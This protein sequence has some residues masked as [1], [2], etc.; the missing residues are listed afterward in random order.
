[1]VWVVA[2]LTVAVSVLTLL[3]L[4]L[5]RSH[6]EL[7]RRAAESEHDPLRD[8]PSELAPA[9]R[10]MPEGVVPMPESTERSTIRA[11]NG[12]DCDLRPYEF[13]VARAPEPYLLLAFLST[14]CLS[15]LDIWRDIIDAGSG[16]IRIDAGG[17]RALVLIV[18]KGREEENLGKARALAVDTQVPVVLSGAAWEELSVPGSPYFA[19]VDVNSSSVVGAGSAQNWTQLRS[20][21]SDGMLEIALATGIALDGDYGEGRGYRSIIER[22]DEELQRAG[23]LPGHPSLGAPLVLEDRAAPRA[24]E[25]VVGMEGAG[26]P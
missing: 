13:V 18:L 2:A 21:A 8:P 20:L 9:A 26:T 25:T 16:A 11:I 19:L 14:T 17:Q 7:L 22:E 4:G 15:C 5:L 23:I 12:I 24:V 6:A 10:L 3:V 1:M